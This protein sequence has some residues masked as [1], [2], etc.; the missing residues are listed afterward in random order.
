MDKLRLGMK[1]ND[2]IQPD[3]RDL[4]D[5]L[6]RL[7]ILQTGYDGK[8]RLQKWLDQLQELSASHEIDDDQSRNFLF[9]LETSYNGFTQKLK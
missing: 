7:S 2:E 8:D 9:D 5:E 6:N 4:I 1:A 3:L